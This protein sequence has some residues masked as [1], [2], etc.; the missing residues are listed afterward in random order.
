MIPLSHHEILRHV[1]PFA[2]AG[3]HVDLARSDRAARVIEF[4][5]VVHPAPATAARPGQ[6]T[7]VLRLDLSDPTAHLLRTVTTDADLEATLDAHGTDLATLLERI[8]AVPPEAHFRTVNGTMIADSFS[9]PDDPGQPLKLHESRTGVHGFQITLDARTVVGE[10]MT[11]TLAPPDP[12]APADLPADLVAV[13]GAPYKLM[14]LRQGAWKFLLYAPTREPQRST[15][16]LE[17]FARAI[18][19]LDQVLGDA[20]AAFH[21]RHR[22]ARWRVWARRLTPLAVGVTIIAALPLID[23]F[24]LTDETTMNPLIFGIP[25]F[26]IV[27]FIYVSRHEMPNLELPPFPGPLAADAWLPTTAS[28]TGS[29]AT[30]EERDVP[31]LPSKRDHG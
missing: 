25:N 28:S 10:P 12:Q 4:K 5:P 26:L 22:A 14:R 23:R 8:L 3:H 24:F 20:P 9:C 27:A 13:L 29:S 16:T 11:V 21:E 17:R 15:V 1:G 31:T 19:H 7:E 30:G 2:R 6:L 18:A